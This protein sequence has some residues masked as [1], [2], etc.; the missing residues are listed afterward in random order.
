MPGSGVD[1]AACGDGSGLAS[2]YQAGSGQ[3][4]VLRKPLMKLEGVGGIMVL[5]LLLQQPLV[6]DRGRG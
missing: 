6:A 4:I 5:L 2:G 3:R 1:C